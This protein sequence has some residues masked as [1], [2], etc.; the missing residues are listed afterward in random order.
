MMFNR[1]F[2]QVNILERSLDAGAMRQRVIAQNIA[3]AETPNYK[4]LRVEFEDQLRSAIRN[5]SGFTGRRTRRQ[6]IEIGGGPNLS[7]VRPSTVR[8]THF[9][10]R[11]DGNNVDIEH[12]MVEE[13]KNTIMMNAV[14][15]EM[16]SEINRLRT[17]IKEG[18]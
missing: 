8:D 5:Q 11:M 17:A 7:S 18:R 10:M 3:N 14:M 16:N 12:Q 2:N 13:A 4:S 6:H 15:N 9:T 1:M